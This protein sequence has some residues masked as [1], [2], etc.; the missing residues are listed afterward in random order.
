ML[1]CF[2][3]IAIYLIRALAW[4]STPLKLSQFNSNSGITPTYSV[5]RFLKT[6]KLAA[7]HTTP[8]ALH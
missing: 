6:L 8:F 3:F 1:V 2:M 4:V 5:E 7:D